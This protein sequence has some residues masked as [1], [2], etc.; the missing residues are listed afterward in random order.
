M[1]GKFLIILISGE[2]I[3]V[4]NYDYYNEGR[5]IGFTTKDNRRGMC[6]TKF[7]VNIKEQK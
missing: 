2:T 7:V 5:L 1:R 6:G 4:T 3:E